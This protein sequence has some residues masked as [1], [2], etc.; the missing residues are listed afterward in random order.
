MSELKQYKNYYCFNSDIFEVFGNVA[1]LIEILH[2]INSFLDCQ[3]RWL[4]KLGKDADKGLKKLGK[5]ADK[6]IKKLT[7]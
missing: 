7:K 6:G 5:E 4:K 2:Q 3:Q 1:L